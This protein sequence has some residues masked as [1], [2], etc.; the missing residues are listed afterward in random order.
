MF[1]V[2]L[3]NINSTEKNTAVGNTWAQTQNFLTQS[4]P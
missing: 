2:V 1:T 4:S 3:G